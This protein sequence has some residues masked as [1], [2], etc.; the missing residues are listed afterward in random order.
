M[1]VGDIWEGR[2]SATSRKYGLSLRKCLKF[3]KENKFHL[4]LPFR[5]EDVAIY[6]AHLKKENGTRGAI[7]NAKAALKWVHSFIPGMNKCSNP[8]NDDM[9]E[10]IA[11]GVFRKEGKPVQ[12]KK[13]ISGFMINK[14]AILSDF[15]NVTQ[16]RDFLIVVCAHNLLL[17][18]DE[19]SHMTCDHIQEVEKGYIIR[20]PNS[21]TDKFRNGKNVFLAKNASPNSASA[22]L[23]KYLEMTGLK[24]GANHF[25]FCPIKRNTNSGCVKICNSILS[26]ASYNGIVKRS[27][28]RL[29]LD[30]KLYGTHSC[31]AG[32]ATDLAPKVSV[33]ELLVSGRWADP[34]SIRHYVEIDQDERFRLNSLAQCSS[35]ARSSDGPS[36]LSKE[37]KVSE[38]TSKSSRALEQALGGALMPSRTEAFW[39]GPSTFKN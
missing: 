10:K 17:R 37:N 13:P 4:Q 11:S 16:L 38:G 23:K 36:I 12:H 39:G 8:M 33:M 18:H 25:L 7:G 22:L 27:I 32:G 26:Y 34:R 6:L 21:K 2:A 15:N 14:L 9:L 29:G 3:F 5:A 20:I 28:A 35:T 24:L 19:I 30:P 1:L 31:R